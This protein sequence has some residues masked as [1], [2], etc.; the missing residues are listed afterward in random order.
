MLL[1]LDVQKVPARAHTLLSCAML[2]STSGTPPIRLGLPDMSIFLIPYRS[3]QTWGSL[4]IVPRRSL[5]ARF[6][7]KERKAGGRTR[8]ADHNS[9]DARQEKLTSTRQGNLEVSSGQFLSP[10][11]EQA[12]QKH[13]SSAECQIP[14]VPVCCAYVCRK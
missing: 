1:P 10:T 8:I 13:M 7:Q 4:G 9:D 12:V 6:L 11:W 3:F 5:L 14:Y 2:F